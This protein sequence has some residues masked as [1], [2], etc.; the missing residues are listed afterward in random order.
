MRLDVYVSTLHLVNA[1][2]QITGTTYSSLSDNTVL[3]SDATLYC[4]TENKY[5]PQVMWSYVDLAGTRSD[6]T[7][8]TDVSTGVSNIQ[9]STT[10]PG[11]YTCEMT[12]NGGSN[13]TYTVVMSGPD[14]DQG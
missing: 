13:R 3:T 9:V 4:V 14:V 8:A 2:G 5:T 10:E 12:E 6:L 7:S 11:Y 1:F